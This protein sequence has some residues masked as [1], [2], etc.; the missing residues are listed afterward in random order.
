MS[1]ISSASQ[2]M[3]SMEL[4]RRRGR[5]VSLKNCAHQRGKRRL[6]APAEGA[7]SR[8]Q[9][10]RLMPESTSSLPPAA[11]KPSDLAQNGC[12]GQA[13]EEPRVWGMTQKVQRL[14]QPS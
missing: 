12:G 1:A 3:G 6:G 10:P 8:P 13:R 7:R 9:R 5:S 14:P 11:T 4:R 2:S